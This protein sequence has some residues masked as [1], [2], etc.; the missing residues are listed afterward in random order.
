MKNVLLV[1]VSLTLVFHAQTKIEILIKIVPVKLAI[2]KMINSN[3]KDVV[4][5][6]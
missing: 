3:V 4:H 5:S 1:V 6:V 2:S